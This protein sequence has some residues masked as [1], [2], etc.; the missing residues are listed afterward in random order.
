MH[1]ARRVKER[2]SQH[3]VASNTYVIVV[4]LWSIYLAIC[5]EQW[6]AEHLQSVLQTDQGQ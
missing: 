6:N 5:G 1:E 3:G 4:I 2:S